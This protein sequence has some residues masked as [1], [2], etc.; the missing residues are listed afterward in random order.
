VTFTR[1]VTVRLTKPSIGVGGTEAQ[2]VMGNI[3]Y[4]NRYYFYNYPA[5]TLVNADTAR[6]GFVG[7]HDTSGHIIPKLFGGRGDLAPAAYASDSNNTR[8]IFAQEAHFN[9]EGYVDLWGHST[10]RATQ[11][12]G[13]G[14]GQPT[15]YSLLNNGCDLCLKITLSYPMGVIQFPFTE[16]G[17][18]PFR[19]SRVTVTIYPDGSGTS[20]QSRWWGNPAP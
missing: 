8:N 16:N 10:Y 6:I 11:Q 13:A 7:G 17:P 9:S 12:T 14:A 2:P 1:V 19:P 3:F 4:N 5:D 18:R 20:I 15:I